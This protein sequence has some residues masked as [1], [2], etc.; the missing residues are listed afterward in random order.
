MYAQINHNQHLR[1]AVEKSSILE[2]KKCFQ[3][4]L[5]RPVS[6]EVLN[7]T[8]SKYPNNRNLHNGSPLPDDRSSPTFLIIISL[9]L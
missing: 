3:P 7:V 5:K 9:A 6:M 4:T 8:K 1:N 2:K